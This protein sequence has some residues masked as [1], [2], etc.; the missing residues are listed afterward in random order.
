MIG[1]KSAR[2]N[3][4]ANPLI[5]S[6]RAAELTLAEPDFNPGGAERLADPFS[7]LRIL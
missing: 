4:A 3:L 5:P 1:M 6:V 7:G 2:A